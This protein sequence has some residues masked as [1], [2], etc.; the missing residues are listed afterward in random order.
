MTQ[1]L[2]CRDLETM[3]WTGEKEN[4]TSIRLGKID[5][6]MHAQWP[7]TAT[8]MMVTK[9]HNIHTD[10]INYQQWMEVNFRH[11]PMYWVL[12]KRLGV[13]GRMDLWDTQLQLE[14]LPTYMNWENQGYEELKNQAN[15][16]LSI[17]GHSMWFHRSATVLETSSHDKMM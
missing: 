14:S 7:S 2:G 9:Y 10:F 16:V 1:C 6:Y 13:M 17:R 8:C 4:P 12:V 5:S 3:P 11:Q 15:M